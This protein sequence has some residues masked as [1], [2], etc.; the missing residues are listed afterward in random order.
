MILELDI[1]N[2]S[3]GSK[4]SKNSVI[5]QVCKIALLVQPRV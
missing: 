5:I 1:I 3:F 4:K 2:I